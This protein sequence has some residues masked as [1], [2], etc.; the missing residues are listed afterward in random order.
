[1]LQEFDIEVKDKKGA[2][3]L[4]VDHLI[5]LPNIPDSKI[6]ISVEF[7]DEQLYAMSTSAWPCRNPW[8]ADIVNYLTN[9]GFPEG[10]SRS[11]KDKLK[12]DAKYYIR[13][14]PYLWKMCSGSYFN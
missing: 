13:D 6:A 1:M 4:V 8:Y 9:H 7:P 14:D 3:N 10:Y 12:S 2:E 5:R 11:Q